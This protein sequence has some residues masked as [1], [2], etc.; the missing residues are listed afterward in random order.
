[1]LSDRRLRSLRI[2]NRLR[3]E[4]KRERE[5]QWKTWRLVF[6]K[7]ETYSP[8]EVIPIWST[9]NDRK[10]RDNEKKSISVS[11]PSFLLFS[12]KVHSWHLATIFLWYRSVS[13]TLNIVLLS[14]SITMTPWE[15]FAAPH[16]RRLRLFLLCSKRRRSRASSVLHAPIRKKK[17]WV[18]KEGTNK[19][20][21]NTDRKYDCKVFDKNL[22]YFID[23][24]H[25]RCHLRRAVVLR[26][27]NAVSQKAM[28]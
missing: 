16:L 19:N 1:M 4:R 13:T 5:T 17:K 9:S 20:R 3:K 27:Q 14:L 25:L 11:S 26:S 18:D 28:K 10:Q 2:C 7:N 23:R 21:T 12:Y 24:R 6:E 8:T 15:P 22:H